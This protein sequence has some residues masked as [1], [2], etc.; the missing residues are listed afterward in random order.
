MS[1][2]YP[3]TIMNV[4][5][6]RVVKKGNRLKY[7]DLGDKVYCGQEYTVCYYLNINHGW[8]NNKREIVETV[9]DV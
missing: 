8:E 9:D 2:K 7:K 1:N 3:K 6:I 5:C 4:R